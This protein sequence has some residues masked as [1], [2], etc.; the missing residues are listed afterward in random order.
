MKNLMLLVGLMKTINI[1]AHITLK[2]R[3]L[4]MWLDLQQQV[5]YLEGWRLKVS[6]LPKLEQCSAHL[7]VPS[8]MLVQ[9]K[10]CIWKQDS[11]N[12]LPREEL[13]LTLS[14]KTN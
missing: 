1:W 11:K 10:S 9:D 3:S 14:I 4:L 12:W 5:L 13:F 7:D 8:D 6:N 2:T